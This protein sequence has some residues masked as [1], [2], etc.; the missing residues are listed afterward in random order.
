[1]NLNVNDGLDCTHA[2]KN[3]LGDGVADKLDWERS[4][5]PLGF[6]Q[7]VRSHDDAV[8]SV[9]VIDIVDVHGVLDR[10]LLLCLSTKVGSHTM[11][12]PCFGLLF[13]QFFVIWVRFL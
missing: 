4:A 13:D 7:D 1:M 11:R 3:T 2:P 8:S 6:K 10:L 5:R 12:R 9:F